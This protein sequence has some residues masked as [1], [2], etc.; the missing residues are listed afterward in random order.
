MIC[1]IA[2]PTLYID[3]EPHHGYWSD[4]H[5]VRIDVSTAIIGRKKV[6][7]WNGEKYYSTINDLNLNYGD[8]LTLSPVD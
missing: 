7:F 1:K 4:S 5:S 3:G 2:I 6:E 8:S